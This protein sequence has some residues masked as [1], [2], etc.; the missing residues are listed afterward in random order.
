MTTIIG[1][2]SG[3][4]FGDAFAGY[5]EL[6]GSIFILMDLLLISLLNNHIYSIFYSHPCPSLRHVNK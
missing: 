4:S 5:D 3:W 1:N 6:L 2:S